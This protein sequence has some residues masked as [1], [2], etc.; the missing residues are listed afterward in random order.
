MSTKLISTGI[1]FN[2]STI[3]TTSNNIIGVSQTWQNL[4]GS[5]A[6][7]TTYTN[8]T[9]RPITVSVIAGPTTASGDIQLLVDGVVIQRHYTN[10]DTSSLIESVYGIVPPGST[11]RVNTTNL[12]L[13]NWNELR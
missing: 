3:Q 9:S 8:S 11:Y 6:L 2:D 4:T 12:A 1:Q 13:T 5:R 10:P 7:A